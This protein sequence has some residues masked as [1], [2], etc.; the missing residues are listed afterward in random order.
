MTFRF[1]T[2]LAALFIWFTA[3]A[4]AAPPPAP[5]IE[6]KAWLLVDV[7]SGQALAAKD[8]D[9]RLEPASLTKLMTSYLT[10]QALKEGRL[11]LDQALPVSTKA[12]RAE[13]SRMFLEAGKTARVED[14]IKGMIVQSGNDACIV[15]AE[16]VAGSE[17]AFVRLMNEQAR[18]LGMTAT[19]FVN[20]T[21]LPAS[22]H[23]STARDLAR[24][25][26]ALIRDFP[27]AYAT[28]YPLKEFTYAGIRQP[29]RNRL[30]WLDPYVDGLKTGHTES[31]GYCLIASATRDSRRLVSVVL[32]ANNDQARARESQK[33][34]NF[35]FQHYETVKLYEAN[36]A[37]TSLRLYKGAANQLDAGFPY[38]FHVTVPRGAAA[39]IEAQVI[40][41]QPMLAPVSRGQKVGV[42]RLSL[43][44]KHYADYPLMA[45]KTVSLAGVIGRSWDSLML[46]FH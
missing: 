29:N 24:L 9:T 40:T 31:A 28:Y 38:D 42:L 36:S 11:R 2:R 6:A 41:E 17:E 7:Q 45:L 20:A 34:L 43:A 23:Y 46:L 5:A 30:L 21:G 39:Q 32:G 13:G 44:G 35:G 25:A 33:L 18:R 27:D 37:V 19:Q 15:L 26:A 14:L 22:G 8:A 10:L 16:G 3:T 12:W 1:L 4:T